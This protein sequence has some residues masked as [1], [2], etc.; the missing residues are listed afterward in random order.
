[1][2]EKKSKLA[3]PA[4]AIGIGLVSAGLIVIAVVVHGKSGGWRLWMDVAL[5]LGG[6]GFCVDTLL[7]RRKQ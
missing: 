6:L 7:A 4:L 2:E 3:H 1:M 5:G